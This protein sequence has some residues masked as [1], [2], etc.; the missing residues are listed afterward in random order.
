M[1]W[2]LPSYRSRHEVRS[3]LLAAL[4]GEA[5][6]LGGINRTC[7][8][9]WILN[10]GANVAAKNPAFDGAVGQG[11][12]KAFLTHVFH[13]HRVNAEYIRRFLDLA[14]ARR[15]RV[16]W[17][18][19]PLSP[20]LQDLRDRSGADDGYGRFARALQARYPGL[21][22]LDARHSNY[23]H[24]LFVDATHLDGQGAY[25]LSRDVGDFLRRDL[26]DGSDGPR[27]VDLPD[28]RECPVEVALED[29]EQSRQAVGTRR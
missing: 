12:A 1:G 17:L 18:L 19:P 10:D 27:W 24:S 7:L 25:T 22:I 6:P 20:G 15:V 14:A 28:Y 26:A 8:R 11:D 2:L 23:D 21:T 5:D 4:R 3:N 13:C 29:V 9:N 16:Y